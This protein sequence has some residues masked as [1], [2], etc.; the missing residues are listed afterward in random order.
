[1]C[2]ICGIV[3]L[4]ESAVSLS[5]L[6]SM[7]RIVAHRGPDD[8][9]FA[10]FTEDGEVVVPSNTTWFENGKK[11]CV[12]LG[13]RRLSILD[14]SP[15][16]HQPMF[17]QSRQ[18]CIVY[19]GEI[20][21]Y[22]ELRKELVSFGYKFESDSDTEVVLASYRAWGIECQNK[23]NGMWALAIYDIKNKILFCSRDRF[24]VKPFYYFVGN[25]CLVFGSEIKQLVEY[26]GYD[27]EVEEKT[28]AD[29][30]LWGYEA[31]TEKTF[32][33]NILCLPQSHYIL[34]DIRN[35]CRET[36]AP[37]RYWRHEPRAALPMDSAI[38]RFKE[39]FVE[40]VNIR[41]RSDVP[42]G[43]TL[44]GG[45]DSSSVACVMAELRERC[46]QKTVPKMF[47][48]VFPD[49]GFSEKHYA[50]AVVKKTRFDHFCVG[51][52]AADIEKDWRRFV[53][54]MEEP[55]GGLAYFSNWKIYQKAREENT[56]VILNG[57]G[58]DELLLGYARYR[59]AYLKILLK[60]GSLLKASKE[61][62]NARIHA[63][64]PLFK[65]L[66]FQFYFAI[67]GIRSLRRS[68]LV[69]PYLKPD[70]FHAYRK[71][72]F[73]LI[74]ESTNKNLAEMQEKEFFNYQLQHLLRHEDRV[75]MA[76]SV[77]ARSP[78]LDYR[79]FNFILSQDDSLKL[80]SGW[81]KYILRKA[82][83]GLIPDAI[84]SRTDKM[85]FDTP[86]GRLLLENKKHFVEILN[87]YKENQYIDVGNVIRDFRDG[88]MDANLL[89]SIISFCSWREVFKI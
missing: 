35:P 40:A 25:N 31:H 44:S 42:V 83:H 9:G 7:N 55:F 71:Q 73:A 38:Q 14:L 34:T 62:L 3:S 85:G 50:D 15:R 28:L 8:E 26:L 51:P 32:F 68:L 58:G 60:K 53:W 75:A 43:V 56:P 64:M 13:H 10:L 67:P 16:A 89:C 78:F 74:D 19:N 87:G 37:I 46:S 1:M 79:L 49:L 81:S 57:Q 88:S 21:N 12:G 52:E 72:N 36:F 5:K 65:Q 63:N 59:V 33:K 84:E 82:M 61:M 39:L 80:N 6:Q 2:G 47:T 18:Y 45:L 11:Y 17:D 29:F 22:K 4:R 76:H 30:L 66:A 77:E 54:H 24:G 23:F 27:A 69:K 70:F 20:Y 41:L 48:A 86:T